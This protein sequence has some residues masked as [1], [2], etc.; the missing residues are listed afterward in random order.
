MRSYNYLFLLLLFCVISVSSCKKST[1]NPVVNN[2]NVNYDL[3][4]VQYIEGQ[5]TQTY[6]I[7]YNAQGQ[8]DSIYHNIGYIGGYNSYTTFT[9]AGTYYIVTQVESLSVTTIR[10]DIDSLGR[11]TKIN[12]Y[13]TLM[14]TYNGDEMMTQVEKYSSSEAYTTKYFWLNG[15]I[16]SSNISYSYGSSSSQLYFYNINH[17]WQEGDAFCINDFL[18]YGKPILKSKHLMSNI[19]SAS[20]TNG[21]IYKFDDKG[22][23]SQVIEEPTQPVIYN[24]TYTTN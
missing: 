6:S 23:I 18:R 22:R 24:Y 8:V 9:Y 11:I 3:A 15:D 1:N 16:D 19:G 10:I 13:D 4:K 17:L 20:S 5:D 14:F 12:N 21:M 7:F 2:P